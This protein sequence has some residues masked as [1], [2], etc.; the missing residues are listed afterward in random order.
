MGPGQAYLRTNFFLFSYIFRNILHNRMVA[1]PTSGVG[2][3]FKIKEIPGTKKIHWSENIAFWL[4]P[5]KS[6]YRFSPEI[7]NFYF[8]KN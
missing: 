5:V 3:L 2:T 1:S 4:V 7:W 8:F 6:E